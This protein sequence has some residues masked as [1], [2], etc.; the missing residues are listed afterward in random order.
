MDEKEQ[1]KKYGQLI[2]DIANLD[3]P[4]LTLTE[5]YNTIA[6]HIHA[7]FGVPES[8]LQKAVKDAS[9]WPWVPRVPIYPASDIRNIVK[10]LVEGKTLYDNRAFREVW[11]PIYNSITAKNELTVE[12]DGTL[13]V[14]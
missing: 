3:K 2:A 13:T 11:V 1:I 9:E 5:T 12:E 4:N 8:F 7:I 6:K 14:T 10:D